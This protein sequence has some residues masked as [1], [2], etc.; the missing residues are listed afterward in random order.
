MFVL[1]P[2]NQF[3]KDIKVLKRRSSQNIEA[4]TTFLLNLEQHGVAGIAK[5]YRPHKLIGNYKDNW[6]AH[7]KPDLLIIW[8]EIS[9]LQ[10]PKSLNTGSSLRSG[11]ELWISLG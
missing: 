4:I 1:I 10:V 9:E 11:R 7:I 5:K 6:E 8:F 3:K 2:T